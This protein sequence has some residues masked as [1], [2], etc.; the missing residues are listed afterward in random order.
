MNLIAE[1]TL[2]KVWLRG[3]LHLADCPNWTDTTVILHVANP[4]LVRAEDQPMADVLDDFLVSHGQYSHHTVAETIFPGY[5]YFTHGVDGV[6]RVYP[7]DVYP[8]IKGH[9]DM[10]HW[11]T[12]AYR[13]LR[14][15]DENG[16]E[17]NPLAFCIQK[18][19]DR[20]RKRAAYE[21]GLGFGFDLATYDDDDDRS[22]RMGG[23]CLSHLSFKVIDGRVHLAAMYRSHYY[24]Q[25]A[26][27][28]LLG[29]ARLQAFV[30]EQAELAPGPLVCHSTMAVLE[31]GRRV[32][33]LKSDV[34]PLLSHCRAVM[35]RQLSKEAVAGAV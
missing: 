20:A 27:G 24:M 15:R 33:W 34:A 25:R 18:M 28:N 14:R 3:V 19:K 32:G 29:L 16:K 21:V 31:Y 22:D 17:Y 2:A 7:E 12:Y 23:P 5:E 35:S 8:R 6:Y 11:G 9:K 30:A 4:T 13:L 1:E 26:Y 10:R